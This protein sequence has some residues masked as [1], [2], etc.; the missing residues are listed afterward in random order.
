MVEDIETC[1]AIAGSNLIFASVGLN[2]SFTIKGFLGFDITTFYNGETTL[3]TP[4]VQNFEIQVATL[5][6]KTNN[7]TKGMFFTLS[8]GVYTHTFKLDSIPIP[9]MDGWTRIL[10]NWVSKT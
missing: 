2:P 6:C 3:Y 9:S 1:L 7:V 8:D 4:E 5:D 10:V